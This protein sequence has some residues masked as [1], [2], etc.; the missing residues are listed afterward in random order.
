MRG[1]HLP[2]LAVREPR[3]ERQRR[4]GIKIARIVVLGKLEMRPR[5]R[6]A[7]V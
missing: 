5:E 1:R 2:V 7:A 4:G 3:E 6:Q